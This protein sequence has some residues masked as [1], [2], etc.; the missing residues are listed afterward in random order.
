LG[1]A[2][3]GAVER[4]GLD[5]VTV[6]A[7]YQLMVEDAEACARHDVVV[8]ADAAL[9]GPE[10]FSFR[11]LEPKAQLSF[12]SHSVDPRAVLALAEELFEAHPEGYMLGIRGYEFNEFKEA[13][14]ERAAANLAAALT[15][16]ETVLR[17]GA[18]R[19]ACAARTG[20]DESPLKRG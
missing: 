15:F 8:F 9:H 2:L 14:S 5:G 12:S 19:S 3:A 17:K 18:F 6:D 13:L 7:N 11:P 20:F 10:P 4:L 16:I 1:P